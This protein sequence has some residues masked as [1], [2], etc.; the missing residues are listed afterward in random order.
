MKL[1]SATLFAIPLFTLLQCSTNRSAEK[2]NAPNII[3]ILADDMGVGD[4]QRHYPDNK[5][6]TPN[7]DKLVDEGMSFSDAH[8]SSAVCTPSRYGLLTGRYNWR[9]PLQEWVLGCYEPPLINSERT[10]MAEMLKRNGYSTACI[11]KWHLGWNWPGEREGKRLN[12]K[13]A[14]KN[15][16]WD[17]TKPITGGPLDHGFDYFFGV[18]APNYPPF[19]Y[20]ENDYVTELPESVYQYDPDEGVV[21]PGYFNGSPMAPG[22]RFDR[23]LPYITEKAVEYIH[24]QSKSGF[25]FF[26]YFSLTTPHEPVVPTERFKGKSGI[27]PIADFIM[28]TDWSAGQ[29]FKAVED[30]GISENTII[31]F[32]ADNGHA[33]YTGW[34]ELVQA[35]HYP[36]G[37]YRGHKK[38][39]WEGGHRV[40]FIVK[41]KGT[42]EEGSRSNQLICLTDLYSTFHELVEGKL[43]PSNEGEDSFSFL[44]ILKGDDAVSGR[45]HLV[46]HSVRGEFAYR[47]GDWKIVYRVPDAGLGFWQDLEEARGK[48]AKVE[49]FNLAKDIAEAH[50]SLAYYADLAHG[51]RDQLEKIVDM[52]ASRKGVKQSNDVNVC[53]ETLQDGRW[54]IQ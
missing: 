1:K 10:T 4:I 48:P 6:K 36:S 39:I 26:L 17:Y 22:W 14:L 28:E 52:G 35:G 34:E 37:P 16:E 54:E 7:L 46:S 41:W 51:L 21:M 13:N 40:P 11:G 38:D 3:V 30:A 32:T 50:D 2:L 23:I 53:F 43:P 31:I 5:I 19:T 12:E 18:E 49:L 8:S 45:D 20:I 42:I 33:D 44:K 27:A 25:P 24:N 29:I 15:Y 47:K 9:S